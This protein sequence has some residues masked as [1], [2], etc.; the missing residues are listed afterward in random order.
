MVAHTPSGKPNSGAARPARLQMWPSLILAP[1]LARRRT[2]AWAALTFLALALVALALSLSASADA[3]RNAGERFA[4]KVAEAQFAIQQRLMAYEQV[5]RGGVALFTAMGAHVTRDM[6]HA[7]VA[8]LAIEGNYPGIQGI[9]FS[10]RIREEDLHTHLASIRAEGFPD[11]QISPEGVRGEYTSIIFLEPFDWRNKRAFGFDMFSEPMRRAAMTRARDEGQPAVSGK[12]ILVQETEES[13]QN[14]FLMYMPVYQPEA[15]SGTVAERRAALLGYVYAPFRARDLL[16]GTLRPEQFANIRLEVF[17]GQMIEEDALLYDSLEALAG[18]ADLHAFATEKLVQTNG[19]VW[20]IRYTSRPD[21]D[22]TIDRQTPQLILF[23]GSLMSLLLTAVIWSLSS[24]RERARQ[25][26]KANGDLRGEITERTKLETEL[27]DA[28]DA[29]E[30]A[31]RAKSVFLANM[32]HELRTPLNG[33]LGYAQMLKR[34]RD[35]SEWQAGAVNTIEQSG[36]HLLTLISDILD[37]SKIEA[38]K[39]E[40]TCTAVCLPELLAGV[41]DTLCPKAEEKDLAFIFDLPDG[42][43]PWVEADDKRLRQVLLNLLGNAVKFTDSGHVRFRIAHSAA[44]PTHVRL[45]FEVEDTGI[46]I[47]TDK[48]EAIFEPF[49]QVSDPQRRSAG[50]GLGLSITANL[51]R[52]MGSQVHAESALGAG[53]RFWFDLSLPLA[54]ADQAESNNSALVTGYAGPR[55]SVLIVDDTA[56]NRDLLADALTFAGLEVQQATNGQ[57]GLDQASLAPPDVILMDVMM[58]LM[59]GLEATRRIRKMLHLRQVP[60][61]AIS[62]SVSPDDRARAVAAGANSFIGKPVDL[63]QLFREIGALLNLRWTQDKT[64]ASEEEPGGPLVVPPQD[65]IRLLLELARAGNMRLIRRRAAELAARDR[66]FQPFANRLGQLAGNFD[67]KAILDLV[68][69]HVDQER[70]AA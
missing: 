65:E 4:F 42:L 7:Y 67:S 35:L 36:Q 61:I 70:G 28:R 62:A 30:A 45:R 54:E 58:P 59:D 44:T 21:L 63:R 33:V 32:S 22:A 41:T 66:T 34:N 13:V 11:Y 49:E 25:L 52:L 48:L 20:T 3:R 50:T 18:A 1:V 64:E 55:R 47:P 14:G 26:A 60:I 27:I 19:R 37:V 8:G 57:E 23:G 39:L 43:P 16:Q 17:D 40:L 10:E 6:W 15:A 29:A 51:V 31:N 24:N 56:A 38:G 53:S 69:E 9:G 2:I 68:C 46:G 5:L 12:V